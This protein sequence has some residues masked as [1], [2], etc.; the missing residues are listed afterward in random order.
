EL[1]LKRPKQSII[2][3]ALTLDHGGY[4]VVGAVGRT[5]QRINTDVS[6]SS[7][8]SSWNACDLDFAVGN[9]AT[10]NEFSTQKRPHIVG[11]AVFF[12]R[13]ECRTTR[14]SIPQCSHRILL[15]MQILL[16]FPEGVDEECAKIVSRLHK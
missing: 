7:D 5:T 15:S 11:K 6:P 10:F 13:P 12:D 4:R 3:T 1:V 14:L 16:E 9:H 2:P 8:W